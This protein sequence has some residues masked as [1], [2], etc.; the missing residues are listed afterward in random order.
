MEKNCVY[1]NAPNGDYSEP[2]TQEDWAHYN[3]KRGAG[4]GS[5]NWRKNML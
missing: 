5:K 1:Y 3:A 2:T 4:K